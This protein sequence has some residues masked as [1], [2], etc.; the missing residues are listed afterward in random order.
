[1]AKGFDA[2]VCM[3]LKVVLKKARKHYIM[4]DIP[5]SGDLKR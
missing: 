1:M 3:N 5:G 4:A 2:C